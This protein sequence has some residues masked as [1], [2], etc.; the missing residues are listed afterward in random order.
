LSQRATICLFPCDIHLLPV[1]L[2]ARLTKPR[3]TNVEKLKERCA[4]NTPFLAFE[5]L[6]ES[7]PRIS[8]AAFRN[9]S[10]A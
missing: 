3:M 5:I 6:F 1:R 7:R 8:F 2:L 4:G 9:S 10:S